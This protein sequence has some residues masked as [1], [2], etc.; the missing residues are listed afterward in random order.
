MTYPLDEMVRDARVCMD[1]DREDAPLLAEGDGGALRLDDVLRSKALE[2]VDWAHASAPYHF[3]DGGHNLGGV[4]TLTWRGEGCGEV[5]LPDDFLRLLVFEMS[6]WERSVYALLTP[7]DAGYPRLRSRVRALRGTPQRPVCA[8]G[9][10]GDG[11]VLEFYSCRDEGAT[12]SKGVYVPRARVDGHGG[13]E[14]SER[15]R[16]GAVYALAG[17]AL[18]TCGE[19]EQGSALMEMAKQRL[20][21]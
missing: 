14:V 9:V 6:D 20:Q 21:Q 19:R 13:V 1:V 3:L 11:R 15:C 10:R 16:L 4:D 2:A 17:L 8:L 18:L 7:G 5:L 12:V